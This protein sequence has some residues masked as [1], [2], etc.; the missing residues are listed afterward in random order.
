MFE[1][2]TTMQC[3]SIIITSINISIA[4]FIYYMYKKTTKL[5]KSNEDKLNNILNNESELEQYKLYKDGCEL[6]LEQNHEISR[7]YKNI[8]I[9]NAEINELNK[10]LIKDNDDLYQRLIIIHQELKEKSWS[11]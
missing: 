4:I 10:S 9:I 2:I 3:I 5:G 11:R 8:E 6:Q 1:T 7:R